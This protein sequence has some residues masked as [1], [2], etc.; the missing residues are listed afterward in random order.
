MAMETMEV[1]TVECLPPSDSAVLAT[2]GTQPC[3]CMLQFAAFTWLAGWLDR[4]SASIRFGS[5][6]VILLQQR[7]EATGLA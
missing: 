5:G 6:R 4:S 1:T 2:H 3:L 7:I